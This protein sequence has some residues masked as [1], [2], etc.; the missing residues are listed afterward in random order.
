MKKSGKLTKLL[1]VISV[2]L[3]F[4]TLLLLASC[5]KKATLTETAT[6]VETY[7]ISKDEVI[8]LNYSEG[9]SGMYNG[10]TE[11][12][13]PAE[14]LNTQIFDVDYAATYNNSAGVS[15]KTTDTGIRIWAE[16]AGEFSAEYVSADAESYV[17]KL[18]IY[19]CNEKTV[20]N[21]TELQIGRASCRERVCP[22][23]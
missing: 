16:R 2:V 5:A 13:N 22:T 21:A 3:I 10:G 7:F 11:I 9:N 23:V 15:Y 8:E 1:I 18:Q 4:G 19:F 17:F 6:F 12:S 14:F 20:T